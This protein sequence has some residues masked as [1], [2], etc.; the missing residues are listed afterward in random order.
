M[1]PEVIRGQD[2]GVKVDIWSLGIVAMEMAEGEPPYMEHP[3]LRVCPPFFV[4]FS[5]SSSLHFTHFSLNRLF[6]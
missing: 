3:P 6:F 1:A 4:I 5:F 2:Y